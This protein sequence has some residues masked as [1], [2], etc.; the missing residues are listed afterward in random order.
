[1]RTDAPTPV[2]TIGIL[3]AGKLGTTLARLALVA[4]YRVLLAASGSAQRIALIA[5]VLAPGAEAVTAREAIDG[6]DIVV[7]AVPLGKLGNVPLDA[8]RGKIVI[9]AMNY[10][11]PIDGTLEAFENATV[12]SS[13]L[14]RDAIP[15]ATVVK[16]I[17][18][19]GYHELEGFTHD[20]GHPQ[21]KALAVASD[22]PDAVRLVSEIV[23]DFGFDPVDAG[24][25][26]D[27]WVLQPGGE[28]FG[29]VVT[30]DEMERV[31]AA[32][33]QPA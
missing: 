7:L 23:E 22:D 32:A 16:T 33:R 19:M 9:D 2:R 8:L 21:R 10:W 28:L 20:A 27:T 12:P 18:H 3:G 5:E 11:Q 26:A 24:T 17:N 4:D 6:A 14:V 31:L 15:G 29:V 25:L 13:E 30:R 1:M